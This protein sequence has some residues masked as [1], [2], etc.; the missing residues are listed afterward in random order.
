MKR[1]IRRL[2]ALLIL[3]S[4]VLITGAGLASQEGADEIAIADRAAVADRAGTSD[5][6]A[7]PDRAATIVFY[8]STEGDD[9]WSGTMPTPNAEG[10]DGP[11]ATIERARNEIRAMRAESPLRASVEVL[12]RGG[13]YR[14][15]RPI[16]FEPIDSGTE[17]Y[18]ITYAAYEEET[19]VI[20]GGR[21]VHGLVEI[22]PGLYETSIPEAS[23]HRW[24]FR[25]LFVDGERKT[26][27]RTPNTGYFQMAGPA[28]PRLH[29]PTTAQEKQYYQSHYYRFETGQLFE[30]P[31]ISDVNIVAFYS[32]HAAILPLTWVDE[33]TQTFCTR[34][35]MTNGYGGKLGE[36][37]RFFVENAPDSLDMPGEW[38]LDRTTG[39]L[40]IV[41]EPGERLDSAAVVA[42]VAAQL[43]LVRGN[44]IT[45]EL[46]EHLR[47]R[48]LSF[49]HSEYRLPL[50]GLSDT[51]AALSVSPAVEFLGAR[52]VAFED[53]EI[54]HVGNHA[55]WIREG[56]SD[57]RVLQNHI[58]DLGGGGIYIGQVT[59]PVRV[60]DSYQPSE[61]LLTYGN[62][63]EN[64]YIHDLGLIFPQSH[65]VWIGQSSDNAIRHNEISYTNYTAISL[66]WSW[67]Y[68]ESEC[69]RN[70]VEF[71]YIHDVIQNT[72]ADGGAIYTLGVQRDTVIRNNIIHD[73]WGYRQYQGPG[74]YPDEGSSGILFA[75]NVVYR[76]TGASL[77][78]HWGSGLTVQN[79][80]FALNA[81]GPIVNRGRNTA[82]K[83]V[84]L[85]F[86]RNIIYMDQGRPFAGTGTIKSLDGNLY[87]HVNGEAAVRFPGGAT[88]DQWQ[89]STG[90]DTGSLVADPLFMD[91][92]S[93]DFR[94]QDSSPAYDLGFEP[95]DFESVGL[96]GD[97]A[98]VDLPSRIDAEREQVSRPAFYHVWPDLRDSEGRI[99]DDFEG[100]DASAS[101]SYFGARD[102]TGDARVTNVK[103]YSG[104]ASVVLIGSSREPARLAYNVDSMMTVPLLDGGQGRLVF[105]L[106]YQR[107]ASAMIVR[108]IDEVQ[109]TGPAMTIDT[110]G[111]RV[112][113]GGKQIL[114]IP[115]NEWITFEM[116][117]SI[118]AY[119]SGEWTLRVT[120]PGQET[121]T[122]SNLSF[123]DE[124]NEWQSL[125]FEVG[126]PEQPTVFRSD[127][128]V[129]ALAT[130][131]TRNSL[132]QMEPATIYLDAI[133][134]P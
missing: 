119:N 13:I 85:V 131:R 59:Q 79:N 55:L 44:P 115:E 69:N 47:F 28:D 60:G 10:T 94:L 43:L 23:E 2:A 98:W 16:V 114:Q 39:R 105:H 27:A 3:A 64:N 104:E 130:F 61:R 133:T 121:T 49:Q 54:A 25:Q 113:V 6:T 116:L 21:A 50:L 117:A 96:Y 42:P 32:W 93:G 92:E 129:D 73:V 127:G 62:V 58:Y 126:P 70:I 89:S 77:G 95:L 14:V 36:E 101:L 19:P 11:F 5:G 111:G 66:G 91:P 107:G 26:L 78:I 56:C 108:W 17:Q 112:L 106:L 7:T 87:W 40:R 29:P 125:A 24:V 80:V 71:N 33:E 18:P 99:A 8:V 45:G 22:A 38:Q 34:G 4:V 65:G 86:E 52:H 63:V 109:R 31:N 128:S 134:I 88:L 118:G 76:T 74:I 103:A 57:I 37:M 20:S 83:E 51:Q 30:W 90:F 100:L 102:V 12:V 53:N 72:L 67:S 46:V 48:G 123:P 120:V 75:N 35:H 97:P 68:A 132:T 81:S 9:S 122:V 84:D 41:A 110:Y 82:G 1:Q 124:F 15:E